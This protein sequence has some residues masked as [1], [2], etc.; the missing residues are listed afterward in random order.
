[1]EYM[2]T[3]SE[4]DKYVIIAMRDGRLKYLSKAYNPKLQ[5]G[6]TIK[7][8]DARKFDNAVLAERVM[9]SL[10]R[11]GQIAKIRRTFELMEIM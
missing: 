3:K 9:N 8:N 1:M 4:T 11:D 5:I 6:Y 7:I 10:C 2:R